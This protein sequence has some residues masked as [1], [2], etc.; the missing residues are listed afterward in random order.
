MAVFGI[1]IRSEL[2]ALEIII[3]DP[4]HVEERTIKINGRYRIGLFG[5]RHVFEGSISI[6]EHPVTHND[7]F[8]LEFQRNT[9]NRTRSGLL[10]YLPIED[11]TIPSPYAVIHARVLFMRPLLIITRGE[12]Y[13]LCNFDSPVIVAN[14]ISRESA[15]ET[16]L[17]IFYHTDEP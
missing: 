13:V 7:M 3:T 1:P 14:A 8:M 16:F 2:D 6:L 11:E 12:D 10:F 15:I 4:T 9:F 5:R 17:R